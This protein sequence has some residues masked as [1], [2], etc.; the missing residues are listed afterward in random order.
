MFLCTI[1]HFEV[2]LDLNNLVKV[3]LMGI[4]SLPNTC[5]KSGSA[6]TDSPFSR[7]L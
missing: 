4:N 2:G 7:A 6:T 5:F 3:S 1:Y